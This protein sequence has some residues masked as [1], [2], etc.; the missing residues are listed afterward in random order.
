M[1]RIRIRCRPQPTFKGPTGITVTRIASATDCEVVTVDHNG[2]E[3]KLANVERVAF[4][5]GGNEPARATLTFLNPELDVE[6]LAP[7]APPPESDAARALADVR[8]AR[9]LTDFSCELTAAD[10]QRIRDMNPV[11][12][13]SRVAAAMAERDRRWGGQ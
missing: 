9:L 1:H 11:E 6:G 5:V 7:C 3:T 10:V 13:A 12:R 4:E 2:I 8:D